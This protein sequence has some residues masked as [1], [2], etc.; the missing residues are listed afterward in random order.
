[1]INFL[2]GQKFKVNII[3]YYKV[4]NKILLQGKADK[5]CAELGLEWEQVYTYISS[6]LVDFLQL[7]IS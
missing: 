6:I 1:M 5:E 2:V 3:D 4:V 7:H